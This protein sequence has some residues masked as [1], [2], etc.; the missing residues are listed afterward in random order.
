[1]QAGTDQATSKLLNYSKR[2][3]LTGSLVSCIS[4]GSLNL[5]SEIHLHS[6]IYIAHASSHLHIQTHFTL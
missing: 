5:Q 2:F 3:S 6:R 1:M 4:S